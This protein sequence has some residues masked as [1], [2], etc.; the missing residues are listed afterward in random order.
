MIPKFEV[1]PLVTEDKLHINGLFHYPERAKGVCV[2]VHGLFS[3]AVTSLGQRLVPAFSDHGYGTFLLNTRGAGTVTGFKREDNRKRSGY[4]YETLG[5]VYENFADCVYDLQ[6]A[7]D[8]LK[9][10]GVKNIFFV[11]HSTGCQK[12]TYYLTQ[13]GKQKYVKGII[14]LAPL[15]DYA[16]F[17]RELGSDYELALLYAKKMIVQKRGQE[18]MP[19]YLVAETLSAQ[20][21]LSLADPKSNEEIFT[22][23]SGKNPKSLHSLSVP[24]LAVFGDEDEYN[25]R[26][27]LEL[28]EWFESNLL[29]KKKRVEWI[30]GADHDFTNKEKELGSILVR[31]LT[32]LS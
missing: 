18:I 26:P 24:T 10:H 25:G 9:S 7:V 1:I 22:Y 11:G 8:F 15:S 17:S 3:S 30:E 31:W 23:D 28:V 19:N 32:G 4:K 14:L 21:F 20:R 5:T 6:S 16:V 27:V 12:S 29:A 13:R 2:Y